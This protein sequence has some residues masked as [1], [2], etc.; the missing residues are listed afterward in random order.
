MA[1]GKKE[2]IRHLAVQDPV[3]MTACRYVTLMHVK[4]EIHTLKHRRPVPFSLLAEEFYPMY[5]GRKDYRSC[6]IFASHMQAF[7][8]TTGFSYGC[9]GFSSGSQT[10]SR[11]SSTGVFLSC[12]VG[13][14]VYAYAYIY[15]CM[16]MCIYM[17][18]KIFWKCDY[19][20]KTKSGVLDGEQDRA[21]LQVSACG[22]D[23]M[24][25]SAWGK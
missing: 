2:W 18:V 16:Y 11:K 7:Q 5:C 24:P 23:C 1:C 4:C 8:V 19:K 13:E 6:V 14:Y 9:V 3:S 22:T 20:A 21:K 17:Y 12:S 15:T 25:T 10:P